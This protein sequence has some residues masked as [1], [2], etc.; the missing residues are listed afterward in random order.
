MSKV[1][2]ITLDYNE[3]VATTTASNI[4]NT[5]IDAKSYGL[6]IESLSFTNDI[7]IL[8]QEYITAFQQYIYKWYNDNLLMMHRDVL[9]DKAFKLFLI[10][11]LLILVSYIIKG[12]Y[13]L[14]K[15]K[16]I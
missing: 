5:D 3:N 10:V 2:L 15:V 1:K 12:C 14:S 11:V 4:P 6:P 16:I 9:I 8:I 13:R 7:F